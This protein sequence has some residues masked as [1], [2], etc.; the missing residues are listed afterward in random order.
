MAGI[1]ALRHGL[2]IV[3]SRIGG[4]M[5][6]VADGF[7][8]VLCDLTPE[9]FAKALSELLEN[10]SRLLAMRSASLEKVRDFHLPERL[11]DYE[12]VLRAAAR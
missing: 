4:L 6:V 7:N 9:D 1:E 2:A 11:D 8:G 12:S 10:P 3:G 5:D